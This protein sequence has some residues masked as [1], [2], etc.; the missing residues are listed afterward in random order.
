MRGGAVAASVIALGVVV[1]AS[2]A[3]TQDRARTA[4]GSAVGYEM[5]GAAIAESALEALPARTAEVLAV[6]AR[7]AVPLIGRTIQARL[8]IAPAGRPSAVQ[9]EGEGGDDAARACVERAMRE[10]R[11]PTR[12][13]ETTLVVELAFREG[14]TAEDP[15]AAAYRESVARALEPHQPAVHACFERSRRAHE[16]P[17][18]RVLVDLTIAADG[19]ITRAEVPSGTLFPQLAECLRREVPQWRVPRPPS[20]PLVVEHRF[21]G[22][23]AAYGD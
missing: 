5:A 9:L 10:L 4:S 6:C 18:G 15:R 3:R 20:A 21:D 7:E 13:A 23:V 19:R 8:T 14:A 17:D 11:F 12:R 1:V 16:S 2:P 22:H